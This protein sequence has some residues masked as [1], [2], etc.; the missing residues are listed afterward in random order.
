MTIVDLKDAFFTVQSP[1]F[2]DREEGMPVQL[3]P[4]WPVHNPKSIYKS[5]QAGYGDPQ[6]SGHPSG[7]TH[8]R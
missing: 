4:V 6:I 8:G 3:P 5:P 2:H 1:P 7:D